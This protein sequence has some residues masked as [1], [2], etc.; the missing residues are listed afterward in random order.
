MHCTRNGNTA[1]VVRVIP[2]M[3]IQFAAYERYK[4]ELQDQ[5]FSQVDGMPTSIINIGAGSLAG[6]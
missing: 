4:L 2:Y 3:G 1:A 6:S 5:Q